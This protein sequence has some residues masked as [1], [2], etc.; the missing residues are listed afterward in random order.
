MGPNKNKK[1]YT[2][3]PYGPIAIENREHSGLP[4]YVWYSLH[5]SVSSTGTLNSLK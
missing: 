5:T 1:A 4:K 2:L 3:Q